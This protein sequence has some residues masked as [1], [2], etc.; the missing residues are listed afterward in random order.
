MSQLVLLNQD[1][2]LVKKLS[3]VS[4]PDNYVIP[5]N[6]I[7]SWRTV[8]EKSSKRDF[9]SLRDFREPLESF[10]YLGS[11]WGQI[12]CQKVIDVEYTSG[13]FQLAD[14]YNVRILTVTVQ[15]N[16][17][18]DFIIL[19]DKMMQILNSHSRYEVRNDFNPPPSLLERMIKKVKS[20]FTFSNPKTATAK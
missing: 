8:I 15:G 12:T 10:F 2:T 11:A 19:R 5:K 20:I 9:N 7:L 4:L 17:V 6:Q 16:S 3:L 1:G 14:R 18:E 13:I